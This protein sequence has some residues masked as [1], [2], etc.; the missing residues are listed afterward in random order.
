MRRSL[1]GIF[2]ILII[3]SIPLLCSAADGPC[4]TSGL[5]TSSAAIIPGPSVLCGVEIVTNGTNDATVIVY[6]HASAASGLEAFKGTVAGANNFGGGFVNVN[7]LNGIYLSIS[8]TE[9]AAIVYYHA[10]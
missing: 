9:A 1:V 3:L 2:T 7:M 5:K 4:F 8:G 6:D 10:K